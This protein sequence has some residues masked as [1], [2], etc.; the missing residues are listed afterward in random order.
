MRNL[1]LALGLRRDLLSD[2]P[3]T[4]PG[5]RRAHP[6]RSQAGLRGIA[7]AGRCDLDGG[8]TRVRLIRA[9]EPRFSVPASEETWCRR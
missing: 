9:D 8:T 5:S 6:D 4:R 3:F 1:G 7:A 2:Y